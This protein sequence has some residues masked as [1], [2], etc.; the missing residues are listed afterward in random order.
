MRDSFVTYVSLQ[1]K[2]SQ[3]RSPNDGAIVFE[4]SRRAPLAVKTGQNFA[5]GPTK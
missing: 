2:V 4:F 1:V 3:N 5:S